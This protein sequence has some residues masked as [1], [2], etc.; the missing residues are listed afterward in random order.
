M[1]LRREGEEGFR[2]TAET[3]ADCSDDLA[4]RNSD[5]KKRMATGTLGDDSVPL[6][7]RDLK[8]D[9]IARCWANAPARA[10]L[11]QPTI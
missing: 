3:V 11:P 8:A 7:T 5:R 2:I 1:R 4:I 9:A 6:P 10:G